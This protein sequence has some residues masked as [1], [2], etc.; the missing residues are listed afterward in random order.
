MEFER[1]IFPGFT[2]F[3][4]LKQIQKFMEDRQC[5][6]EQFDGRIIFMSMYSDIAW[7][8][9]GN[10]E[11]CENNSRA[12]ANYARRFPRGHWSFLGPGSE[13][14]WYGTFS[15]KPDGSGDK[16]VEDMMLELA[17][18]IHPMF[19]ASIALE[20]GELRSKGGG[21]KTIHFNG[22]EP[23]VEFILRAIVSAN[24]LSVYGAVADLCRELSKDTMASGKPEAHYLLETTEIPTEPPTADFRTDE[25]R[26][27]RM[28]QEYEQKFE[29]LSDNQQLS[30]ICSDTGLK[31]V[32][33]GQYITTLDTAEGRS[34]MV[35]LCR[36]YT[37]PRSDPRTRA[38]R[39]IRRYTKI[40]PVLNRHVCHH[41]DRYSIEIEV[42]SL[43]QERTA[44]YGV[45]K[46]VTGTT[47]TIED[48]EHGALGKPIAKARPR[49]KSVI[50]LTP[51]SV[52]LHERKW[53]DINPGDYDHAC[54]VVSK[55]MARLLRHN[56][57]LLPRK[58]TEQ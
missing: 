3:G 18:T 31:T 51:V 14:K 29:Q 35:H 46:Y 15:E 13:K 36:E 33:R 50:T 9:K 40:G 17:E 22:S 16:T 47:E 41:E 37:L 53:M 11:T 30:K 49:V 6:P 56:Q 19:R 10:A 55:A 48:E 21:K 5:E 44:S 4:L 27:G 12:V 25:Q 58:L 52:A 45:E 20:R 32:E 34:G 28:L 23:N 2:T 57:T 26:R 1:K 54:Y 39:W 43:F 38:R 8:A 42:R 7:Q 24:Q